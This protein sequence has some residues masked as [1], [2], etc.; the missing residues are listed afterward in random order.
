MKFSSQFFTWIVCM[1][2]KFAESFI[3]HQ[4]HPQQ[5]QTIQKIH[6]LYG[7][8]EKLVP[9]KIPYCYMQTVKSMYKT[10]LLSWLYTIF[11]PA[12][13]HFVNDWIFFLLFLG[14]HLWHFPFFFIKRL[15]IC[16]KQHLSNKCCS[17]QMKY[18]IEYACL[19]WD[20]SRSQLTIRKITRFHEKILPTD[21]RSQ[22]GAQIRMCA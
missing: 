4:I 16:A 2:L 20:S 5:P 13:N 6:Q 1:G 7:K 15:S 12:L 14:C 22:I 19:L 8:E 11:I 21:F 10:S 9:N 17:C 18:G 3:K